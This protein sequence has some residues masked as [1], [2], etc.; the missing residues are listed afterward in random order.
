MPRTAPNPTVPTFAP[1]VGAFDALYAFSVHPMFFGV[2]RKLLMAEG[3]GFEPLVGRKA[4]A[5]FQDRQ[6]FE[7]KAKQ[8]QR[9][10][11]EKPMPLCRV[12]CRRG[13]LRARSVTKHTAAPIG[14]ALHRLSLMKRKGD[15]APCCQL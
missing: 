4:R 5:G 6:A 9:A 14:A 3:K 12:L 11:H 10:W 8:Y 7:L 15:C 2:G 13:S 1:G